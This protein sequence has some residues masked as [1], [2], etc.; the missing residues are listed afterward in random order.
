MKSKIL[1][2]LFALTF[3]GFTSTASAAVTINFDSAECPTCTN[4]SYPT[5]ELTWSSKTGHFS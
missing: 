3:L 4:I 1:A 2:S 5:T